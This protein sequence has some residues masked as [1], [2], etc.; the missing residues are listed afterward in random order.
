MSAAA[1]LT[2]FLTIGTGRDGE[3]GPSGGAR[4]EIFAGASEEDLGVVF[5]Y[6]TL[7]DIDVLEELEVLEML[8]ALQPVGRS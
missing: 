5:E 6:E 3:P 7:E 8:V 2:L 4:E 1:A